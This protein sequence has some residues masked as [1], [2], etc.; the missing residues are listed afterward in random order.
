MTAPNKINPEEFEDNH[1]IHF[2]IQNSLQQFRYY[3]YRA[4]KIFT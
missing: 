3:T 4:L 2:K 1:Q